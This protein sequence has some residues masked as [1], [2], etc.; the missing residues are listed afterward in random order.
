V[1]AF[2]HVGTRRV[3]V[4]PATLHPTEAWCREQAAA[5][6]R[7]AQASGL[8]TRFVYHDRDAKYGRSLMGNSAGM[9]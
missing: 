7:H 3:F 6:C 5:F 4:T 8:P 2:I 1:L 9:A